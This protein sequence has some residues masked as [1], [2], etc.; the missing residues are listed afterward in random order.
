MGLEL[1]L[2]A[3]RLHSTTH[4]RPPLRRRT[5]ELCSTDSLLHRGDLTDELELAL[6]EDADGAVHARGLSTTALASVADFERA[7]A[8]EPARPRQSEAAQS[9]RRRRQHGRR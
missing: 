6:R 5:L 2:G 7:V 8:C 9:P 3:G 1:A 4:L